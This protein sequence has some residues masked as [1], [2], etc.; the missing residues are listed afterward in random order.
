MSSQPLSGPFLLTAI[1]LTAGT[2][3]AQL[4]DLKFSQVQGGMVEEAGKSQKEFTGKR[5]GLGADP[6][7]LRVVDPWTLENRV[8]YYKWPGKPTTENEIVG[9][10]MYESPIPIVPILAPISDPFPDET[11]RE[12]AARCKAS[13][14][15]P[16]ESIGCVSHEVHKLFKGFEFK[17]LRTFCRSH[18]HAFDVTF[19]ALGIPRALSRKAEAGGPEGYDHVANAIIVTSES[20]MTYSYVIDSG[21]FPGQLFPDSIPAKKMHDRDGD[22]KT[23]NFVLPKLLTDRKRP[24]T[25]RPAK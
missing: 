14:P 8:K 1:L 12:I 16:W 5:V 15:N 6:E 9:Q 22:G 2:V 23:E 4:T 18:A 21:W 10:L 13:H 25:Y 3:Y 19:K 7:L 11:A 17:D 24:Y 20:G